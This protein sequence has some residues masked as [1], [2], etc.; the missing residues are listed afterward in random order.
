MR[1]KLLE[2]PKEYAKISI[3]PNGDKKRSERGGIFP[4]SGTVVA[5]AANANPVDQAE[6]IPQAT[7]K[8]YSKE[9]AL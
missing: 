4:I 8:Y 1:I 2:M 6:K 9:N 7:L 3:N 5:I